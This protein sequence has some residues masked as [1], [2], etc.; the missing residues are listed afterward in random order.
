MK[1]MCYEYC[2][3]KKL[4]DIQKDILRNRVF[5]SRNIHIFRLY[6]LS[7]EWGI[8]IPTLF[9]YDSVYHRK[10]SLVSSRKQTLLQKKVDR[11]ACQICFDP[12]KEHPRCKI[13][14]RLLHPDMTCYHPVALI[15][16]NDIY[17]Y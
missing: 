3:N 14:T 4:T 1:E 7:K 13:C 16:S 9:R 8:S 11:K 15:N 12:L 2:M 17:S 5:I 6:E 10:L